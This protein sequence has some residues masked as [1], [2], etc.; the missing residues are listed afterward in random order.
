M[1][2][3]SVLIFPVANTG[4]LREPYLCSENKETV[5]VGCDELANSRHLIV[6]CS[7]KDQELYMQ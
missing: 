3:V 7:F 5:R 2:L 6:K 4:S 1:E